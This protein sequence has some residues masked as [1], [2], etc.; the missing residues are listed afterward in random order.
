MG[1]FCCCGVFVSC[2]HVPYVHKPD[3][4]YILVHTLG[5]KTVWQCV[6][7]MKYHR[8]KEVQ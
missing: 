2:F 6:P 4:I 8:N 3:H 5:F 1:V 7:V